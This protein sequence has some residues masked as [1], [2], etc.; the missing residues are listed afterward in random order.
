MICRLGLLS[1]LAGGFQPQHHHQFKRTLLHAASPEKASLY[2]AISKF[3]ETTARDG[4]VP[5]DFGVKGGELESKD[6]TP[7]NL[8]ASGAFA[9]V[10]KD[11]GDAAVE[12]AKQIE[13]LGEV[14][15]LA[16][17]ATKFFGTAEGAACPLN[18]GWR[19]LWTTAADATFSNDSKRGDALVGNVVDAVNGRITNVITFLPEDRKIDQLRV[20]IAGTP[21]SKTRLQLTFRSATF[22]FKNRFLGLFKSLVLPVP[23]VTFTKILFFF[24]PKKKP[25]PPPYFDV[26]YLDD[27]LRI[28]QTGDG[29]LFVQQRLDPAIVG[30]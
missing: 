15:S 9:N 24:R 12:V 30:F 29:N 16:A 18:G 27:D 19:N 3:Q 28:Q 26:L 21:L 20:A 17:D 6:R 7:R 2:K 11:V 22:R 13:L 23:A 1:V 4:V 8:L 10:S 14:P 5:V 25:P